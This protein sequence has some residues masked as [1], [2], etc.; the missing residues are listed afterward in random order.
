MTHRMLSGTRGRLLATVGVPA[1]AG[2]IVIGL[3]N[4][5]QIWAQSQQ[6]TR[7]EFEVA[8]VKRSAPI[9][10]SGGVFFGPARGGP[11]TPEPGQIAWSYATLK[12]MLMT[13]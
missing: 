2:A 9:P 10:Q 1:V 11:G 3:V 8:S 4:A 7:L 12:S 6:G 5:P 13:A